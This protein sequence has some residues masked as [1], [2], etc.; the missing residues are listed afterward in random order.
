MSL[1]FRHPWLERSLIIVMINQQYPENFTKLLLTYTASLVPSTAIWWLESGSTFTP[2]F[3]APAGSS[4]SELLLRALS[5]SSEF[6]LR[7]LTECSEISLTALAHS[8]CT[9]LLLR[10]QS[11]HSKLLF[12]ALPHSSELFLRALAQSSLCLSSRS[13]GKTCDWT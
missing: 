3:S 4:C 8:S 5:H 12:R 10:A 11:S 13:Q 7:A 9:E 1:V 6:I 2:L